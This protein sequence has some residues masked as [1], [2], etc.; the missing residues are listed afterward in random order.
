MV[1]AKEHGVPLGTHPIR[2]GHAP[3]VVRF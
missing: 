3:Y 2:S 1:E